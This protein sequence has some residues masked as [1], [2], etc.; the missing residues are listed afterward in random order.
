MEGTGDVA[1]WLRQGFAKPSYTGSNP[2]VASPFI[3][4]A[5]PEERR[6][7]PSLPGSEAFFGLRA[8]RPLSLPESPG[9]SSGLP[10]GDK[11]RDKRFRPSGPAV[12]VARTVSVSGAEKSGSLFPAVVRSSRTVCVYRSIVSVIL[13]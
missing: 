1:K 6:F 5:S 11:Q 12:P 4:A 2:V 7:W 3:P 10:W 8:G 9:V 13:E